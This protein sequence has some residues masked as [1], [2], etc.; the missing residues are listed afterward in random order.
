MTRLMSE[1]VFD[2]EFDQTSENGS[3][4]GTKKKPSAPGLSM[5]YT[6]EVCNY[7]LSSFHLNAT[8]A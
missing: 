1:E 6:T 8:S 2:G 3:H 7:L 5:F 4:N